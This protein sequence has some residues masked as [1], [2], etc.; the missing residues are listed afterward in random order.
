HLTTS[1]CKIPVAEVLISLKPTVAVVLLIPLIILPKLVA[2]VLLRILHVI[3]SAT[4]PPKSTVNSAVLL[5]QN[6]ANPLSL[7]ITGLTTISVTSNST[8][9]DSQ[10]MPLLATCFT[11]LT[12]AGELVNCMS[13]CAPVLSPITAPLVTL[14]K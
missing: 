10:T 7:M 1:T 3:W 14:H 4:T 12:V 5:G 13:A 2:L 9:S 8:G 11:T 6:S